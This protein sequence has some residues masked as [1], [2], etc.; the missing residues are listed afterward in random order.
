MT[1]VIPAVSLDLFEQTVASYQADHPTR[2][3]TNGQID[4][5]RALA[6]SEQ[7]VE[8]IVSIPGMGRTFMLELLA[9]AVRASGGRVIGLG[10]SQISVADL[11]E[12][13]DDAPAYAVSRWLSERHQVRTNGRDAAEFALGPGDVLFMNDAETLTQL[14]RENLL[15]DAAD[16]GAL[17]RLTTHN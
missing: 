7:P 16:S 6:M 1:S 12:Y 17:V 8:T 9:R 5:A 11:A 14:Q 10:P 15:K 3:L 4:Q 13:L 2:R